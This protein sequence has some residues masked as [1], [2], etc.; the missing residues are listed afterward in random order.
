MRVLV[1]S[2]MP[3]AMEVFAPYGEV[4]LKAG[5]DIVSED[6]KDIDILMI[7][8]VTK[9]NEELL[10]NANRLKFVGTATAGCDHVDQELLKRL[11]IGF[12]SAPGSNKESVGDYVL[13]VLLVFAQ[14]YDLDLSKMSIGVVGCGNTGSEV[15]AKAQ[16]L[17]MKVIKRDPPLFDKGM[18]EYGASLEECLN[19]DFTS[20][21]VPLVKTGKYATFHLIDKD[22]LLKKEQKGF[23]INASRGDV[24]DNAA[25]LS[26]FKEGKKLKVWMD[27]FEGEP[28]ITYKELIPYLEGSTAHIAGYSY[29]SKRR[30]AF[31]LAKSMCEYLNI[32]L[33]SKFTVPTPEIVSIDLG[34]IESLDRDL[35]SRLVFSIYDVRRD[36]YL[37]KNRCIDGK[38]F[39]ALRKNYR[40]RREMSSLTLVNV[41][42]EYKQTLQGLG[43]T[44]K[45]KY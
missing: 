11:N 44:I 13:S 22:A 23:L 25:L 39:D 16:A 40:E 18:K 20:F 29:E 21:H 27:V 1:D 17:N 15:I 38:S 8:S 34:R 4:I 19:C 35:I 14:H 32:D 41:S 6:L 12:A 5:R 37:F 24:L 10:K 42:E 31:M 30:A 45:A 7:R 36:S 26:L 43:F 9:V 2:A 33:K 3:N 28:N